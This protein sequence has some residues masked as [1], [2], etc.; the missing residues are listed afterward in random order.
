MDYTESLEK[1]KIE[2]KKIKK[3]WRTLNE[4]RK[5]VKGPQI[6]KEMADQL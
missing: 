1:M 5:K 6:M 2:T 3:G 4:K